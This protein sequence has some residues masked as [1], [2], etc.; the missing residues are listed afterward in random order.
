MDLTLLVV[1]HGTV[2]GKA[3]PVRK[4]APRHKDVWGSGNI[5]PHILKLGTTWRLSGQFHDLAP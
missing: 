3:L 2:R 5:A 1:W 4:Y